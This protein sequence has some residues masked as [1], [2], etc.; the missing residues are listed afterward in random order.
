[1]LTGDAPLTALHVAGEVGMTRGARRRRPS[2]WSTAAA[3]TS[4]GSAALHGSG[5][6]GGGD[7]ALDP[8]G[9]RALRDAGTR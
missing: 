6:G 5:G 9:V 7:V 8:A 3:T 2:C 4:A 1:M